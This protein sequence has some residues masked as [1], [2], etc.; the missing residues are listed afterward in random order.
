MKAI[1]VIPARWGSTRFPGKSLALL[2]GKPMIQWVLERS[3]QAKSLS[4]VLVATDDKRIQRL[5][6]KL[7]A[8]AVMTSPKHPSGTDRLAEAV[9]GMSAEIFVNIQGDEPLID[10]EL[11]DQLVA[12]L[13]AER[14]WDMATA[15]TRLTADVKNPAVCKVVFDKKDQALYFS[16]SPIPFIRESGFSANQPIYWRHIGVYAYRRAFLKR[17]VAELPSLLEQAEALEQLRALH[18]GARIK[19]LK[20]DYVGMGVDT[21]ADVPPLEAKLRQ[22]GL[23]C[24]D[25][26]D[27]YRG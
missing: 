12:V 11:I 21:P 20:S 14:S 24:K 5:V 8:Q 9:R 13:K 15:A 23:E 16:R 17:L 22:M 3:H 18:L 2:C 25:G 4:Q 6:V 7:G 26:K 1:G 19:V 27:N 10:P